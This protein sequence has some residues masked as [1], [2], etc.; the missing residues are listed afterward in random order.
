[1]VQVIEHLFY[2]GSISISVFFLLDLFNISGICFGSVVSDGVYP[3]YQVGCFCTLVNPFAYH[4]FFRG[5]SL[6]S[7]YVGL[8]VMWLKSHSLSNCLNMV[9]E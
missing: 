1:M 4:Q 8:D 2:H 6:K 9:L 5:C 3:L 7:W